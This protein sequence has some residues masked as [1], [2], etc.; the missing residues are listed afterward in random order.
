MSEP[1]SRCA[2]LELQL[3]QERRQHEAL[4]DDVALKIEAELE[5]LRQQIGGELSEIR[6][7]F[8]A[9][10]STQRANAELFSKALLQ[11]SSLEAKVGLAGAQCGEEA[12]VALLERTLDRTVR[13]TL[14][15][16]EFADALI[17]RF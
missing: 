7:G 10:S 6:D 8:H 4:E 15:T 5:P 17:K 13:G 16:L 11:L 12:V 3:E 1:P 2:Q 9:L 14:G